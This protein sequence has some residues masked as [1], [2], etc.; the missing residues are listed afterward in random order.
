MPTIKSKNFLR[1][2]NINQSRNFEKRKEKCVCVYIWHGIQI[3]K[4]NKWHGIQIRKKTKKYKK[5]YKIH[6]KT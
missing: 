5:D 1:K 2:Y 4:Q 6:L 3:R